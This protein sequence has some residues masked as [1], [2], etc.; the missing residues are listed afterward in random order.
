MS[1][2]MF[3]GVTNMAGIF[4]PNTRSQEYLGDV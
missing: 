2:I 4:N 3:K 1:K